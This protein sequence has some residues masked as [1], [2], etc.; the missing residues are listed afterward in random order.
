[1]TGRGRTGV[2]ASVALVL[3]AAVGC[4]GPAPASPASGDFICE[5]AHEQA[6]LIGER[7]T[8]GATELRD[9]RAVRIDPPLGQ[10]EYVVA[11]RVQ[12]EVGTWAVGPWLG[13]A[14]IMSLDTVARRWSDWGSAISD[15]SAAGQQRK[16]LSARPE[17]VAARACV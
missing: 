6:G 9:A 13:G 2:V 12:G 14:R 7:L 5:P 8:H 3:A 4:R 10:Y 1:M 16:E 11:A 15:R 17:V